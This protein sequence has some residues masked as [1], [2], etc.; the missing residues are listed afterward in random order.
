MVE[1]PSDTSV[2]PNNQESMP[3]SEAAAGIPQI[4]VGVAQQAADAQGGVDTQRDEGHMVKGIWRS[5][6][7]ISG[8]MHAKAKRRLDHSEPTAEQHAQHWQDIHDAVARSQALLC[9]CGV[10]GDLLRCE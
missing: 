7:G 3:P 4:N 10:N 2:E 5:K 6:E 1:S 9:V 8:I